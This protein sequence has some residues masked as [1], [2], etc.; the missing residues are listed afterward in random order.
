MV[1]IQM[2]MMVNLN[3][4]PTELHIEGCV[5]S[6]Y[7]CFFMPLHRNECSNVHLQIKME[8]KATPVT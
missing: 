2:L 3:H 7:R 8:E 4:D 6:I 1:K 5:P